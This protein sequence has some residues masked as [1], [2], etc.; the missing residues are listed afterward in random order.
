MGRSPVNMSKSFNGLT[1]EVREALREDPL[2]GHIFLFF[3]RRLTVVKL[4]LWTR[5]GFT[6]VAKRLKRGTFSFPKPGTVIASNSTY[7]S[8]RLCSKASL[9]SGVACHRDG[10]HPS[11][12]ELFEAR[13]P[14]AIFVAKIYAT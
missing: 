11:I 14:L 13:T 5:G 2:S 4:N 1:D 9:W 6:I 7:S 3:N 8:W 10:S 12:A